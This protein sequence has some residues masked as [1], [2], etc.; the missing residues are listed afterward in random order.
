MRLVIVILGVLL[1]THSLA[2]NWQHSYQQ[3]IVG[4]TQF[5]HQSDTHSVPGVIRGNGIQG[6]DQRTIEVF[7]ALRI[8]MPAEVE[9]LQQDEPALTIEAD[10]NLLSLI[11][12]EVKNGTLHIHAQPGFSTSNPVRIK[13]RGSSLQSA[14]LQAGGAL[15]VDSIETDKLYLQ[16]TSSGQIEVSGQVNHLMMDILGSGSINA[17]ANS[18]DCQ[19]RLQGA[20]MINAFCDRSAQAYLLGSGL[21]TISGEPTYREV[22]GWGAG[23]VLFN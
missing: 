13:V 6:S 9:F 18:Q 23:Q 12:T 3:S 10:E 17:D 16:L 15:R 8:Q 20:G 7:T 14:E 11:K 22:S 19:V 2:M 5:S 21:V 4:G 1:S